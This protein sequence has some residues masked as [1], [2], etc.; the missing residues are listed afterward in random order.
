MSPSSQSRV[1]KPANAWRPSCSPPTRRPSVV[2]LAG[3]R[4][5]R[6]ILGIAASVAVLGLGSVVA[7]NL[8]GGSP[9][10]APT[11]MAL[12]APGG[13]ATM[14][15]CMM[16]DAAALRPVPVALAGT[17]VEIAD[18]TV[19]LDVDRWYKGGDAEQ[20]TIALP[21]GDISPALIPGVDFVQGKSFLVSAAEGTVNGCGFSGPATPEL[22][23]I[24]DEAFAG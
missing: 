5:P 3:R 4:K 24:Y 21:P 17:V 10:S 9:A 22:T 8:D 14:Q 16:L 11:T 2:P 23:K 20:V 1:R 18:K 12:T 19:T 6:L 15:M 13:D 7:V